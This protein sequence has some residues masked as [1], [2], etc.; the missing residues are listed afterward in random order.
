[1]VAPLLPISVGTAPVLD[2]GRLPRIISPYCTPLGLRRCDLLVLHSTEGHERGGAA[3]DVAL[4]FQDPRA[5]VSCQ[6]VV[7][8]T[9]AF[10]CVGSLSDKA[11]HVGSANAYSVGIEHCGRA[12]Q[13]LAQWLDDY[14]ASELR[15]SVEVAAALCERFSL[16]AV[17][18]GGAEVGLNRLAWRAG[19]AAPHRGITT[20]AAISAAFPGEGGHS[21]PGPFFPLET[22][23]LRVAERLSRRP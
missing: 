1:M 11:W 2:L 7:D 19:S 22:Y 3:R 5:R 13:S 4:W 8:D 15:L 23:V 21:D 9:A 12:S 17:A 10:C 6:F 20:H 18:V 14:S 16:P